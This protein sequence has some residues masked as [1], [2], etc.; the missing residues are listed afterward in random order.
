MEGTFRVNTPPVLLGYHKRG[1]HSGA[2]DLGIIARND[3]LLTLFVTIEPPLQPSQ[4]LAER[5]STLIW[6]I[7][8]MSRTDF[9]SNYFHSA[10]FSARDVLSYGFPAW[11]SNSYF[12]FF[13]F[14][15]PLSGLNTL[16]MGHWWREFVNCLN[17]RCFGA[18]ENY[19]SPLPCQTS[20]ND[21]GSDRVWPCVYLLLWCWILLPWSVSNTQMIF[22]IF[23]LPVIHLGLSPKILYCLQFL[24]GRRT[25]IPSDKLKTMV[26]QN[27]GR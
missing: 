6:V 25:V 2:G 7:I 21:C 4:P 17:W 9:R 19:Q 16:K 12:D 18:H 8:F 22:T 1:R 13:P 27:F 23:S 14:R 10:R 26:M 5:V 20:I 3:T 11:I 24:W 15:V